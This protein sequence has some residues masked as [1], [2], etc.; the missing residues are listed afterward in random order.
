MARPILTIIPVF[1]RLFLMFVF[2]EDV[3]KENFFSTKISHTIMAITPMMVPIIT[4]AM[5]AISIASGNNSK[6]TMA[7]MSPDAK[8]KIKLKNFRDV[9]LKVTPMM[10]PIVVPKVPKNNPTK[11]VFNK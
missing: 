9:F 2:S 5:P 6:Q 7:V 3:E 11:V 8:D 1:N 4:K 10:P